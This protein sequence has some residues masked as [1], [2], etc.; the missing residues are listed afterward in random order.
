[1]EWFTHIASSLSGLPWWAVLVVVLLS[2]ALTKG[3]DA[4][5]KIWR[6]KLEERQYDDIHEKPAQD[7]LVA[8]L[9]GRIEKLEGLVDKQSDKLDAATKAHANCEIEQEK[10]RGELNVMKVKVAALERHDQANK[11]HVKVVEEAV[12][13]IEAKK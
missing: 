1:M 2:V 6:A 5:L 10:L 7:A 13:A 4:L 11:E 3:V 8:E 9:K 12:K